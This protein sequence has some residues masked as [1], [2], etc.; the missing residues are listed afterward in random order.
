MT[1]LK[2]YINHQHEKEVQKLFK[3]LPLYGT[4]IEKPYVKRLNYIDMLCALPFYDELNIAKT[5]KAFKGF[6]HSYIV[7]VIDLKNPSI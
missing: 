2:D 7:E 3:E 6:A 1:Q 5:S 4:S